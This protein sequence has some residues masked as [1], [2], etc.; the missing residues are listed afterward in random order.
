MS[1]SYKNTTGKSHQ[2]FIGKT[3]DLFGRNPYTEQAISEGNFTEPKIERL[4]AQERDS[5]L[6]IIKEKLGAMR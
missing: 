1:V 5:Y 4:R 3:F 2:S 6:R